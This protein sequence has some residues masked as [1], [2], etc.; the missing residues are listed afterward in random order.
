M[1]TKTKWEQELYTSLT[2]IFR[3]SGT[4]LTGPQLEDLQ[5]NVEKFSKL[6]DERAASTAIEYIRKLQVAVGEGFN[7]IA[8]DIEKLEK[9]VS[10]IK[11]RTY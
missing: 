4:M 5:K 2:Q 1:K 3:S 10:D 9:R 6:I 11:R 7:D 8:K